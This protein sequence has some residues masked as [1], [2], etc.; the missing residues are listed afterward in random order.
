MSDWST[1]CRCDEAGAMGCPYCQARTQGRKE[2]CPPP[3]ECDWCRDRGHY[4]VTVGS[5]PHPV[6]IICAHCDAG[7][8]FIGRV[9]GSDLDAMAG[10]RAPQAITTSDEGNV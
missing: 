6:E 1:G 2:K 3:V 5:D 4:A 7:V 10:L 9:S 8:P